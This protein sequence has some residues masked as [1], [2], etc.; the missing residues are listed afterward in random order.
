MV[1]NWYKQKRIITEAEL[2]IKDKFCF[3]VFLVF[4]ARDFTSGDLD[5][6][7]ACYFLEKIVAK[8]GLSFKS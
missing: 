5:V 3:L 7:M 2:R 1:L 6:M 8:T 4:P